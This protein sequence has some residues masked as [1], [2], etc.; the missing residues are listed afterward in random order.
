MCRRNSLPL[1]PFAKICKHN[2]EK[3]AGGWGG[4]GVCQSRLLHIMIVWVCQKCFVVAVN[5][6][7][8]S[9]GQLDGYRPVYS[10][11]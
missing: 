7:R 8:H 2:T 3:H 5:I 1:S 10:T 9:E 6:Q 4:R 11:T